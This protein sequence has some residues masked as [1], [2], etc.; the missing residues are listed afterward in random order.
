MLL[1]TMHHGHRRGA[2]RKHPHL[3]AFFP[4][5][6]T[7]GLWEALGGLEGWPRLWGPQNPF[8]VLVFGRTEAACSSMVVVPWGWFPGGVWSEEEGLDQLP[9]PEPGSFCS[10]THSL[11]SAEPSALTVG[12]KWEGGRRGG[13]VHPKGSEQQNSPVTS[14][15]FPCQ[16][17]HHQC[18]QPAIS[19]SDGLTS[20]RPPGT[21]QK[22]PDGP[23]QFALISLLSSQDALRPCPLQGWVRNTDDK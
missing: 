11:E 6:G 16:L 8:T 12:L 2:R 10:T 23:F 9:A 14:P 17:I 3:P 7:K 13:L 20:R 4:Q 15:F 22:F 18:H 19:P 21:G 1:V 5:Q